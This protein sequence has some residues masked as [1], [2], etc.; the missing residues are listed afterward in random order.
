MLPSSQK[1]QIHSPTPLGEDKTN[2][3]VNAF[4]FRM[5][6]PGETVLDPETQS[7][8]VRCAG[9]SFINVP[10]VKQQDRRLLAAKEWW[11]GVPAQWLK[12]GVL[13]LSSLDQKSH[14]ALSPR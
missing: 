6:K 1:L 2:G 10:F 5:T 7:L 3:G 8:I 13:K 12:N 14:D 9:D 4:H 11:N